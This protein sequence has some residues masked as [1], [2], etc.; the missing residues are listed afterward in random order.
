MENNQYPLHCAMENL[1][2]RANCYFPWEQKRKKPLCT[3]ENLKNEYSQ[4]K[5]DNLCLA[6]NCKYEYLKPEMIKQ[7][8][9]SSPIEEHTTLIYFTQFSKEADVIDEYYLMD[10]SDFVSAVGGDLG[11]FIGAG[12]LTLFEGIIEIFSRRSWRVL[13]PTMKTQINHNNVP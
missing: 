13:S 8:G 1:E 3:L 5:K 12:L 4:F 6:K 10:F 11:I 7:K 9:G 2:S